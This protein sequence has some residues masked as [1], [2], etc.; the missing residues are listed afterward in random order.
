MNILR[1]A[2]YV[3]RFHTVQTIGQ[4]TVAEHSFF[5]CLILNTILSGE[6][7]NNLLKAALF[8]DLAEVSTG[9]VPA[10]TKWRSPELKGTLEDLE[11]CF[12]KKHGLCVKLTEE[13][14][15]ALKYAD[16]LEL[17]YFCSDQIKL[18][19]SNMRPVLARGI[20]YLKELKPLNSMT[21]QII[22][23]LEFL[24]VSKQ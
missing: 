12:N 11:Q 10:T 16:M 13:E 17:V 15:L 19:N 2:G 18:G 14:E 5:V 4:Q 7:S 3:K 21:S 23:G 6:V 20:S 9:D 24:H 8:H 1:E 22:N